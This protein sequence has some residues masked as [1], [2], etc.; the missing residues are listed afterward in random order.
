MEYGYSINKVILG[1]KVGTVPQ[2]QKLSNNTP[3]C[4]FSLSVTEKW[5]SADGQPME[6]NNWFKIEVLGKN[7]EFAFDT[8]R[9]G[10][11]YLI[12]GYL[13]YE[14]YDEEK[15]IVKVRAFSVSP[16]NPL[17]EPVGGNKDEVEKKV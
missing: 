2:L 9:K 10:Q 8:V 11:W 16:L 15:S 7:A 17:I 4:Y 14:K 6:R 3:L 5:T 12:D 13:R 1:G